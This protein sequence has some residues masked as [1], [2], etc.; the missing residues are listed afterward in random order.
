MSEFMDSENLLPE[1]RTFGP[2]IRKL[3]RWLFGVGAL[4]VIS[5]LG[6]VTAGL[7]EAP[8]PHATPTEAAAAAHLTRELERDGSDLMMGFIPLT[9]G[10][11]GIALTDVERSEPRDIASEA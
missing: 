3:S 11:A 2:R 1:E 10:L 5:S 8:R 6:L 4:S 9:I 7:L